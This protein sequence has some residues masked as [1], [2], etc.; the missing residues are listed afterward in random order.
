VDGAHRDFDGDGLT[1]LDEFLGGTDPA[2]FDG[3]GVPTPTAPLA[4][5]EVDSPT[6]TLSWTNATDPTGDV[7]TYD[8]EVYA[9]AALTSLITS[10]AGLAEDASGTTSWTVDVS[11]AEN[12]DAHWRVRAAD[13]YTPGPWSAAEAFF[14][15]E[16]NEAPST[17]VASEPLTGDRVDV[18]RPILIWSESSDVDRDVLTYDVRVWNEAIDTIVAEAS[19]LASAARDGSW[20]VDVALIEDTRYAWEARAVDEH[21]LT[22][23]WSPSEEFLVS[24]VNAAPTDVAWIEPTDGAALEDPSPTMRAT[25][26]TDAEGD[27]ITYEI[28][29]DTVASYDSAGGH[30]TTVPHD[31]SGDVA[32]NL[33]RPEGASAALLL[34]AFIATRRRSRREPNARK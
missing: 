15:N 13:P 21:G 19:G 9:D 34:P 27:P 20:E 14:V 11:L 23:D 30:S 18:L 5:V 31:D 16:P 28:D 8:V 10:T 24:T 3:P 33:A 7:L 25:E 6:P 12:S 22:S 1:N 17:P 26:A 32:W 29:L 4:G 2:S